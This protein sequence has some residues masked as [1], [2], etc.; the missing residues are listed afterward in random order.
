[1]YVAESKKVVRLEAFCVV[2]LAFCILRNRAIEGAAPYQDFSALVDLRNDIV[3][4]KRS[5]LS[6]SR[7]ASRYS[8]AQK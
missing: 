6:A 4:S 7:T 5:K 2:D 3:F 1:M 8:A